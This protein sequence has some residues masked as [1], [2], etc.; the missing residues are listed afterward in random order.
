M[1][2]TADFYNMPTKVQMEMSKGLELPCNLPRNILDIKSSEIL[3]QNDLVLFYIMGKP[4]PNISNC[5]SA[6]LLKII[7]YNVP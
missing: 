2:A 7:C 5:A 3:A 4:K 1:S 6:L